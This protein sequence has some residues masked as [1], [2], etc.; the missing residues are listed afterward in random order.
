[1]IGALVN[2]VDKADAIRAI[3]RISALNGA[4]TMRKL[5]RTGTCTQC[6]PRQR[7]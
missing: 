7:G 3:L 5:E 4:S 1:M 2:I 6:A